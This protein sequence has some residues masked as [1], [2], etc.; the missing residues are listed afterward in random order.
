MRVHWKYFSIFRWDEICW[1]IS[2]TTWSSCGEINSRTVPETPGLISS[3]WL[4]ENTT[5]NRKQKTKSQFFSLFWPRP[6]IFII[7]QT[8]RDPASRNKV[9]EEWRKIPDVYLRPPHSTGAH[10]C[11]PAFSST[12]ALTHIHTHTHTHTPQTNKQK[13]QRNKKGI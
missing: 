13:T 10:R 3:S 9:E 12:Q 2:V 11:V 7:F 6:I 5:E 8:P 1:E 4:P